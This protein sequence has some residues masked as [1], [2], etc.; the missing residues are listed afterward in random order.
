MPRLR[1]QGRG[2]PYVDR[3]GVNYASIFGWGPRS[4][5]LIVH[6]SPTR[7]LGG[8]ISRFLLRNDGKRSTRFNAANDV[9]PKQR[10][11]VDHG[12]AGVSYF[13]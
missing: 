8:L 12:K 3:L 9:V 11:V 6:R 2:A 7:L 13:R 4:A 1:P 5:I 10:R